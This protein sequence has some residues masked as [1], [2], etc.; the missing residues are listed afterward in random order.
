MSPWWIVASPLALAALILGVIYG[1]ETYGRWR[2]RRAMRIR[3]ERLQR[4][5]L[6]AFRGAKDRFLS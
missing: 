3:D 5:N 6:G 1:C 4:Y 2:D